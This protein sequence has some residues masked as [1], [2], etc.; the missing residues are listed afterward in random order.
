MSYKI[1]DQERQI[2]RGLP[3]LQRLVYSDG[4][5]PY[6]DF[7]TGIVG[8][9]RGVSY[10]SIAEEL[11]IEPHQGYRSGAPSKDQIR[12]ALKGLEK[13]GLIQLNSTSR[14]LIVLCRLADRDNFVKNKG[15]TKTPSQS[16]TRKIHESVD[17]ADDFQCAYSKAAPLEKRKAAIPPVSGYNTPSLAKRGEII[18]ADFQPSQGVIE[19]AQQ[20]DCPTAVC[21]DELTKFICYHQSR[22]TR[23]CNWDAEFLRWLLRAKQF[24]QEKKNDC[25]KNST[26][27][28][29]DRRRN[30][31][32]VERVVAAYQNAYFEKQHS[33]EH[34]E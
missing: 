16:T 7:Q 25:R 30:A 24:Y 21:Q 18:S 14:K 34:H 27:Q 8:I 5:R 2:L 19:K 20:Q 12:R 17:N 23:C 32:A 6:M 11:Y 22:G 33:I 13:T 29:S 26:F 9:R 10:Q 15:A 4:L 28:Q 1:N 31:S 3:H